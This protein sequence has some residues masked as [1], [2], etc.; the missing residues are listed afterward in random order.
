MK[1][2]DS[3]EENNKL[4]IDCYFVSAEKEAKTTK[5][6]RNRGEKKR[7]NFPRLSSQV[8]LASK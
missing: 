6:L 3:S 8:T 2:K 5:F 4:L 1:T 7:K